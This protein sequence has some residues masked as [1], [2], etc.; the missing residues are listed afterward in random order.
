MR[1]GSPVTER[2]DTPDDLAELHDACARPLHAYLSR[3]VGSSVAEDLVAEAFLVLWEQRHTFDRRGR[4]RA[5]GCTGWR[6]TWCAGTPGRGA[7]VAGL[8]CGPILR[9]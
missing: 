5:C 8:A 6:P 7:A 9:R 2:L 3:R 4:V 1:F